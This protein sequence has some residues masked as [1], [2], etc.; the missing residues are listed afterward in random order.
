MCNVFSF[1]SDNKVENI[2]GKV[3]GK[4][5]CDKSMSYYIIDY[6]SYL[7]M[8][9]DLYPI[10]INVIYPINFNLQYMNVAYCKNIIRHVKF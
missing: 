4:N 7:K 9:Y 5:S 6:S 3:N 2:F 8:C 10:N 1:L